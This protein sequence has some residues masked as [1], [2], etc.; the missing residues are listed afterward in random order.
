MRYI[1]K[2]AASKLEVHHAPDG[3]LKDV[4]HREITVRLKDQKRTM[5]RWLRR[6]A[7]YS[8]ERKI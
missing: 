6:W 3:N 2:D 5:E 4:V 8:R 1:L 7:S